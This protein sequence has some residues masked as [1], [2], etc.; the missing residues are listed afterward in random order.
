MIYLTRDLKSEE[1]LLIAYSHG[2]WKRCRIAR[3]I[4]W[5]I[6]IPRRFESIFLSRTA[7]ITHRMPDMLPELK[8]TLKNLL[9]DF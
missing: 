1:W 9:M 4:L 5:K 3:E 7:L 6:L 8:F 2:V